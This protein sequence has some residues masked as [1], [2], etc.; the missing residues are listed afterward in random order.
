M[1]CEREK[2]PTWDTSHHVT[3]PQIILDS[4]YN[5]L[6]DSKKR[7]CQCADATIQNGGLSMY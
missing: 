6:I 3:L 5:V 2:C 7:R 4:E 1:K